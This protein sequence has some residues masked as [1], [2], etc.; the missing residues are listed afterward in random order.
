MGVTAIVPFLSQRFPQVVRELPDRL[1]QLRGKTVVIDA[2]L[3]TFRFHCSPVEHTNRHVQGWYRL[4][5]EFRRSGVNPICVFDGTTRSI[6]KAA[7]AERRKASARL[8]KFRS[9]AEDKRYQRLRHLSSAL[10]TLAKSQDSPRRDAGTALT[11]SLSASPPLETIFPVLESIT[12]E[13]SVDVEM[14]DVE[15]RGILLERPSVPTDETAPHLSDTDVAPDVSTPALDSVRVESSSKSS[16][17]IS[18]LTVQPPPPKVTPSQAS[19]VVKQLH[20]D[21]Y[22]SVQKLDL[23]PIFMASPTADV[24][25]ATER[26]ISKRQTV[27]VAEEHSLWKRLSNELSSSQPLSQIQDKLSKIEAQS[28]VISKSFH[29]R[30]DAPTEQTYADSKKILRAMGVPILETDGPYEAEGL[31][32][33]IVRHGHADFVASEDTDVLVY[34]VP[35]LRRIGNRDGSFGLID[36]AEVRK[37]L[38]LTDPGYIDFALLLG[39]DFTERIPQIGPARALNFMKKHGSIENILANEKAYPPRGLQ[40]DY[41]RRVRQGRDVFNTLPPPPP[42]RQLRGSIPQPGE[43]EALLDLYGLQEDTWVDDEE[44]VTLIGDNMFNDRPPHEDGKKFIPF[45]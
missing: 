9:A 39:T 43:V 16:S 36:G 32:S 15:L 40:E 26:S 17:L 42:E 37:A 10:R 33:S 30:L 35:L 38:D 18:E 2:T 23:S 1:F 25:H 41:L 31:A 22:N 28:F 24:V 6:A 7:E 45:Y 44:S 29:R 27:L 19:G 12:G 20:S 13:H 34:Q 8:L 5:S 3:I 4:I 14:S 21:F 11:E